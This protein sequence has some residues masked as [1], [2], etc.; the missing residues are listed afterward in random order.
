MRKLPSGDVVHGVPSIALSGGTVGQLGA[1]RAPAA[2]TAT[3]YV[4][5]IP[6]L[7]PRAP[8]SFNGSGALGID[9]VADIAAVAALRPQYPL[10]PVPNCPTVLPYGRPLDAMDHRRL[11]AVC[12]LTRPQAA[13]RW[14]GQKA[15][16]PCVVPAHCEVQTQSE[17]EPV[18]PRGSDG[19]GTGWGEPADISGGG[20]AGARS[21]RGVVASLQLAQGGGQRLE[22]SGIQRRSEDDNAQLGADLGQRGGLFGRGLRVAGEYDVA[23]EEDLFGSRPRSSQC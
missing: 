3:L 16:A 2:A 12:E 14:T 19:G 1:G 22:Y 13:R 6:R 8:E 11:R 5:E 23:G 18:L 15:A 7:T 4:A 10:P 17:M 9:P 20:A 21:G